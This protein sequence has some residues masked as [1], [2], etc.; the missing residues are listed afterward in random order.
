MSGN[1]EIL[2]FYGGIIITIENSIIY[3]GESHEFLTVASNMSF[4]EL[5]RM[6]SGRLGWNMLKIKLKITWMML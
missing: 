2:C 6:L 1:L 5:S 4:N 3:N